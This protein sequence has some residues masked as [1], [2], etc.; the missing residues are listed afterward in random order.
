M[1]EQ[2]ERYPLKMCSGAAL[3]EV[4]VLFRGVV[5]S[6]KAWRRMATLSFVNA[7]AYYAVQRL[8][9]VTVTCFVCFVE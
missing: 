3:R 1:V 7:T 9:W 2:I 8:L 5:Y 6:M 4:D